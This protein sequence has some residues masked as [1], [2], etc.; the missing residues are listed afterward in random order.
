MVDEGHIAGM[1]S[2]RARFA[3]EKISAFARWV[4]TGTPFVDADLRQDLER[5]AQFLGFLKVSPSGARERRPPTDG[6]KKAHPL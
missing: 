5:L 4:I 6:P 1:R 2:T 3:S